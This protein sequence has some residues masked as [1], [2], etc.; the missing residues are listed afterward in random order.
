M[1]VMFSVATIAVF[2]LVGVL[3]T[4]GEEAQITAPRY[5][6]YAE[7]RSIIETLRPN[8]LPEELR[9]K[10]PAEREAVWRDWTS[11]RDQAIRARLAR[12]DEDTVIN[13]LLYGT[14]FTD[15]A[16][17]S[18]TEVATL[19]QNSGD[20][21]EVIASRVEDFMRALDA[22]NQSERLQFARS[23]IVRNGIDS[24]SASGQT[25]LRQFLT[26][27]VRRGPTETMNISNALGSALQRND[28]NAILIEQT[29][30]RDRGLSSDTSILI[31]YAIEEVLKAIKVEG[32]IT[33]EQ[34][35]QVGLIGPGLDFTDKDG[36]YDFYP[37]QTIQPFAVIDSLISLEL[38]RPDE[39]RLT[40]LD[41]NPRINQHLL[42]ARARAR[43]GSPYRL[44]LP[45]NLDLP[46]NDSL[47][48]YW[49][50]FGD[51]IA[52]P[53][54][55][56]AVP[57]TAGHVRI[58]TVEVRPEIVLSVVPED[59]NIV[60]QRIERLDLAQRFDLIVAT[61]VLVYYNV[62]EQSL[63]LN[64]VAHM[65]RPGGLF[66]TNNAVFLLP[67]LPMSEAGRAQ[68]SYMPVPGLGEVHDQL[69]WYQKH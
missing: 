32:L 31:D 21:P 41:L 6:P 13:F 34:V 3:V 23:I 25:Q 40:A 56:A 43:A 58:R 64:N 29:A 54:R 57:P 68:L 69:I 20:L 33:A 48:A 26:K 46:W 50:Q 44:V 1:Q 18:P 5:I 65:L 62:F 42:A 8:L 49:E 45:R 37:Q 55:N 67:D 16:R 51:Q 35:Q 14:S 10:S 7:A 63:A 22:P 15:M 9:L 66:I 24:D 30:F 36:G 38:A 47:A 60:V 39:I 2:L 52:S 27:G 4:T 61:D 59:V 19:T 28:P 11:R 53:D 12:G 17:P